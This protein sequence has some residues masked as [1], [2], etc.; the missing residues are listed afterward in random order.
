M[1]TPAFSVGD[2]VMTPHGPGTVTDRQSPEENI[3][4]IWLYAVR[5]YEVWSED[6]LKPRPRSP[7]NPSGGRNP[8]GAAMTE[9][10]RERLARQKEQLLGIARELL[11][12][13]CAPYA[14]QPTPKK[15]EL[16][17]RDLCSCVEAINVEATP[18]TP[19]FA[20]VLPECEAIA[21][22]CGRTLAE[23]EIASV[24]W[25]W[26]QGLVTCSPTGRDQ[27]SIKEGLAWL[28]AHGCTIRPVEIRVVP[29]PEGQEQSK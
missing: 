16:L 14:Y 15:I 27:Q 20:L 11:D 29:E 4:G 24:E 13:A 25:A 22:A 9:S 3:C 28:A 1:S 18:A 23:A 10:E 26:M 5:R 21:N 2:R 19:G 7:S 12:H 17:V 8:G 6:S